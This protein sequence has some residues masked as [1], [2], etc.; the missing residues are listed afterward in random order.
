MP[1][2]DPG[3]LSDL[4]EAA[5]LAAEASGAKTPKHKAEAARRHMAGELDRL[6]EWGPGAAGRTAEALDGVVLHLVIQFAFESLLS[7]G[8]VK[9]RKATR[10]AKATKAK[11]KR[12][13]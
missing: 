12:G 6:I 4:A 7:A 5:V 11:P 3:I 13:S 1:K 8:K 2:I 9:S 10:K